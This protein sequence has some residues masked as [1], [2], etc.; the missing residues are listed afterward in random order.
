MQN[1]HGRNLI[2]IHTG[3]AWMKSLIQWCIGC[4]HVT[5]TDVSV[6]L[7]QV[8]LFSH[9]VLMKPHKP[10]QANRPSQLLG[11][12]WQLWDVWVLSHVW[13]PGTCAFVCHDS[14]LFNVGWFK[15]W[16]TWA[17]RAA[18]G[19]FYEVQ[20]NCW[21]G[22]FRTKGGWKTR[23]GRKQWDT[24]EREYTQTHAEKGWVISE[25]V[26]G[27]KEALIASGEKYNSSILLR[28]RKWR[29]KTKEW[30]RKKNEK[31]VFPLISPS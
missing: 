1:I 20:I 21:S 11:Q 9:Q 22:W 27:L 14:G 28:Q 12:M 4:L 7:S 26:K 6:C 16:C 19:V 31:N 24:Q 23:P 17:E 18:R 13:Q 30:K 8:A 25:Y 5:Q 3:A 2:D 29:R 15:V 10:M